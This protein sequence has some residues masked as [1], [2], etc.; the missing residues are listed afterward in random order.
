MGIFG[1]ISDAEVSKMCRIICAVNLQYLKELFKSI[2]AFAIAIDA[3]NNTGSLYLDLCM[4]CFFNNNLHNF[5]VLAIPMQERHTGVYQNGLIVQVLDVLA[6]DWRY[7]LIGVSSDGA[8]DMTGCRQ[9]TCTRLQQE[10]RSSIFRI[11]CG[12]HQLDLVVKKAFQLPF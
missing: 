2:W 8:S 7:Q 9:G 12:A 1:T 3:G 11:C 6:P 10:C 4:Q 5:H